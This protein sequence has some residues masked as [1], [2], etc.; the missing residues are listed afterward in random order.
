MRERPQSRRS[1]P[2]AMPI[3]GLRALRSSAGSG[4]GEEG[5]VGFAGVEERSGSV[6]G[7][8]AES[9]GGAFDAQVFFSDHML[10]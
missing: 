9:E 6:V 5:P 10:F 3:E 2:H 1:P 7:E 4:A 8:A